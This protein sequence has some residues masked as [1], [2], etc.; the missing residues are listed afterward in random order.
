MHPLRLN[1]PSARRPRIARERRSSRRG[2][3]PRRDPR[4]RSARA[5]P[6]SWWAIVI[7]ASTICSR[8]RSRRRTAKAARWKRPGADC[9]ADL[10]PSDAQASRTE[11][12]LN[13][14]NSPS[15]SRTET[16]FAGAEDVVAEAVSGFV[17]AARGRIVV[18]GPGRPALAAGPM[19]EVSEFVFLAR[20]EAPDT[21]GRLGVPPRGEVEL[22]VRS[23][24]RRRRSRAGPNRRDT[25]ST[26]R[27]SAGCASE[28][29]FGLRHGGHLLW[30]A[31][32]SAIPCSDCHHGA[33][34]P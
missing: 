27:D 29:G 32:L 15:S 8:R 9:A 7:G 4:R 21:A 3:A 30:R 34:C 17:V 14:C 28:D 12:T 23:A 6:P 2:T 13:V 18:E 24:A 19:H 16:V 20:P 5:S 33:G 26:A 25:P 1:S 31:A 22:P 10:S 11:I